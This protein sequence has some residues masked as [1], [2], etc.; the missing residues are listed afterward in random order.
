[1]PN[2]FQSVKEAHLH[3]TFTT[4]VIFPSLCRDAVKGHHR[5]IIRIQLKINQ[6]QSLSLWIF[7][8]VLL[9]NCMDMIS[10]NVCGIIISSGS[11]R[12]LWLAVMNTQR[13]RSPWRL[14]I[15]SGYKSFVSNRGQC[16]RFAVIVWVPVEPFHIAYSYLGF[17]LYSGY[18]VSLCAMCKC[19]AERRGHAFNTVCFINKGMA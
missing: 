7:F 5:T 10:L 1:M 17:K 18:R 8:V 6:T 16:F 4:F 2:T 13:N 11:L 15:F 14:G 19:E 9:S 3:Q 12:T